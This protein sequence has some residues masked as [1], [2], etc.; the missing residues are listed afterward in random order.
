[1]MPRM[2]LVIE[3]SSL[4]GCHPGQAMPT[5]PAFG[6]PDERL[7]IAR[8]G[9]HLSRRCGESDELGYMGP[10]SRS[11]RPGR[12]CEFTQRNYA[13]MYLGPHLLLGEVHQP[14]EDHEE[15]HHLEADALARLEMRLGRP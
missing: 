15:D 13:L 10:G 3:R 11:A 4:L 5:G 8:A 7:R 9:T 2:D 14:A 6:R 1:M 12:Q